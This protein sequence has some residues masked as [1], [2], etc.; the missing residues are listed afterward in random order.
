MQQPFHSGTSS[1]NNVRKRWKDLKCSQQ[2]GG[3][4]LLRSG[5]REQAK[6]LWGC[7]STDQCEGQLSFASNNPL[8]LINNIPLPLKLLQQIPLSHRSRTSL[9][10]AA[11]SSSSTASCTLQIGNVSESNRRRSRPARLEDFHL[12][13]SSLAAPVQIISSFIQGLPILRFTENKSFAETFGAD[14]GAVRVTSEE[15]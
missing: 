5:I 9:S 8:T 13:D 1:R 6:G 4:F 2:Q 10:L 7:L 11:S 14:E 3:A 15:E 12:G